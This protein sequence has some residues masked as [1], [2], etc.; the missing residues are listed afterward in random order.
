MLLCIFTKA[1]EFPTCNCMQS[2]H[3]HEICVSSSYYST[4]LCYKASSSFQKIAYAF[5]LYFCTKIRDIFH[6][7]I[8]RSTRVNP[9][10][11][12]IWCLAGNTNF[13]GQNLVTGDGARGARASLWNP[14]LSLSYKSIPICI[15]RPPSRTYCR[16]RPSPPPA[17]LPSPPSFVEASR[18]RRRPFIVRRCSSPPQI[19]DLRPIRWAIS[20]SSFDLAHGRLTSI[21]CGTVPHMD[22]FK[23]L[24]CA[25][26]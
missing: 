5:I 25:Y 10:G 4:N 26:I 23:R 21:L 17:R 1:Y 8:S 13:G 16:A 24:L 7:A 2:L 3:L 19:F 20:S 18:P 22:Y 14:Y 11:P 12:Y 9:D 15:L 6:R